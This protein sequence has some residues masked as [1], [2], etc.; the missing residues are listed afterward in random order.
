MNLKETIYNVTILIL[1]IIISAILI[2]DMNVPTNDYETYVISGKVSSVDDPIGVKPKYV[3]LSYPYYI[4]KYLYRSEDITLAKID[5]ADE[6]EGSYQVSFTVPIGL[7]EVILST[8]TSSCDYLSVGLKNIPTSVDLTWGINKCED[9][10][11][12][13][14]E[15]S[16]VVSGARNFLNS[17]DTNLVKKK[18]NSTEKDYIK[19]DIAK[20][21]EEISKSERE[22]EYTPSL[23]H[24]YYAQWYAMRASYTVKLYELKYCILET[25]NILTE[26]SNDSCFVPEY[27]SLNKYISA[28]ETLT[29]HIGGRL[30]DEYP[31]DKTEISKIIDELDYL[32]DQFDNINE[33]LKKC[34]NSQPLINN[35]FSYQKPY[36]EAR[37]FRF[38]LSIFIWVFIAFYLGII[39]EKGIREWVK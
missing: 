3:Y 39:F 19:E 17:L 6:N 34:E 1:L 26:Y 10:Y 28:N 16:L 36:C 20:G 27:Q 33:A 21:R 4:L 9:K 14:N 35:T 38:S 23:L 32:D 2:T 24:A 11:P 7:N 22:T 12:I 8:D 25:E 18:F 29:S 31:Y 30:L 5:W 15:T 13:S 37:H